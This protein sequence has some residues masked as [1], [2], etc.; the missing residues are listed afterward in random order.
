MI[1]EKFSRDGEE[2]LMPI[3]IRK[4]SHTY[5][6]F[7]AT[8]EPS[9]VSSQNVGLMRERSVALTGALRFPIA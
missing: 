8:F 4:V 9:L 6:P 1:F 3:S 7:P 5:S 2:A